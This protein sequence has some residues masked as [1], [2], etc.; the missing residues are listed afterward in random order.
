MFIY[1]G[2]F[3]LA[4]GD[5]PFFPEK[6]AL[7][8]FHA[9]TSP[10]AVEEGKN[11]FIKFYTSDIPGFFDTAPFYKRQLHGGVWELSFNNFVGRS[12][13]GSLYIDIRNKKI[14]PHMYEAMLD[15]LTDYYAGLVFSFGTPAG[16]HYEKSGIGLDSAFIAYLFLKKYLKDS[17]PD[18]DAIAD[19][20][21]HDP[22]RKI[23]IDCIPCGLQ[24]CTTLNAAIVERI[25]NSPM[26]VMGNSHPLQATPLGRLLKNKT[27]KPLYP[28]SAA[29][30]NKFHSLDTHENRFIKFFLQQLL[31]KLETISAAL[32]QESVSYFNP[33][34]GENIDSLHKSINHFLAHNMWQDV[35]PMQ[36]VPV[37]SQVLQKKE[38]YRQLFALYS[39]L[40]LATRCDFLQTDFKNLVEIK[41]VPTLYEYWCFFQI[42]CA[43]DTFFTPTGI[44]RLVY[45]SPVEHTLTTGLCITYPDGINLYFN[46]PY[47][48]SSGVCDPMAKTNAYRT[49][50]SYS[51][52]F[53]PDIVLEKNGRKLIFDAK[54][55]GRK[56]GG[57][58]GGDDENSVW[59]W[60]PE[61][62]NKMH[63]YREAITGVAGS[64]VLF[65]GATSIIYPE[66]G[67]DR[68][69]EGVGAFCLRPD[70]TRFTYRTD[71]KNIRT[72]L[73]EFFLSG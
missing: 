51:Q 10:I 37:N 65:P 73:S 48:G 6:A 30:E 55:K 4:F 50:P 43:L 56:G 41:D 64:F 53:R 46:K 25:L 1:D 54:Y 2:V 15:E 36:F 59:C 68:I 72:V 11:Y 14:A 9:D 21:W 52:G 5:T 23:E 71:Q 70:S 57:F 61:D 32:N 63:T 69:F 44:G 12:R 39:L 45:E 62:I 60:K 29:R 20:F 33:D 35:G 8:L 34:I 31:W 27:G 18:I 17:S 38:G 28:Q 16:Q 13:I 42:K 58:Y 19:I 66:N 26:S 67:L 49:G 7:T 24:D 3:D 22:H 40:Q 47:A